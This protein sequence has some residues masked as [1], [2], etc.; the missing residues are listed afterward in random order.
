MDSYKHSCPFCGQHIEY[1]EG[2]CGKQM[3]CPMCGQT[4]TFPALPSGRK[5][6]TLKVSSLHRQNERKW[7]LPPALA[8][9]L[10]F[11]HWGVVWQCAVPFVIITALLV[12]AFYV[13]KKF[14]DAPETVAAPVVQADPDAWQKATDLT[15]ADQAVRDRMRELEA[16]HAKADMA[17]RLR[18]QMAHLDAFQRKSTEEQAAAAQKEV[19]AARLR[20]DHAAELYRSLGGNIDYRSQIK[21]F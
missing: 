8:F 14:G 18:Q 5:G 11:E 1:T 2:Y 13:K 7:K 12:G 15:K 20:F 16:A 3:Q 17:E 21:N 10:R 9:L 6:T 4:V 19:A